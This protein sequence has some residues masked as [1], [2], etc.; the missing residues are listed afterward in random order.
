MLVFNDETSSPSLMSPLITRCHVVER[1]IVGCV[2]I[3]CFADLTFWFVLAA[4]GL[5]APGGSRY[6][7][8]RFA[9]HKPR[10]KIYA[11]TTEVIK[12]APAPF[13]FGSVSQLKN[14]GTTWMSLGPP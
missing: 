6:G 13:C 10:H 2:D 9:V 7:N 4:H 14:S 1:I 5:Q 12:G 8:R 3:N 11:V